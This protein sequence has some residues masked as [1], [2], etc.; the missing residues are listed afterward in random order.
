MTA[1]AALTVRHTARRRRRTEAALLVLAWFLSIGARLLTQLASSDTIPDDTLVMAAL[2][3][4]LFLASH[5]AVRRLA[6]NASPVLLPLAGLLAGIG[7]AVVAR[8]DPGRA[9]DQGTWIVIGI[10]VFVGVLA[11]LRDYRVLDRYRYTLLALGVVLL[12]LPL[13]PV[14]GQTRNGSRLWVE[15]PGLGLGFQPAEFAK[16]LLVAFFASYLGERRELIAIAPRKV[17][18][19]GIPDLKHFGPVLAVWGLTMVVMIFEKDLGSSLLIFAVFLAMLYTA[20]A[21]A[22]YVLVGLVLF[23]IGALIAYELFGHVQTRVAGWLDPFDPE[24]VGA[25]TFQ[26]A[27]SLFALAAGGLWGTGLGLGYGLGPDKPV[28]LP[29]R[30]TD[31]IFVAYAYELG[32]VGAVAMLLA[33]LTLV[34]SGMR[35]AL[36]CAEPFGKLLAAGLSITLGV[37]SFIIIGG[38]TRVIPLTGITLPFVSYGGSSILANM[39]ILAILLAISDQTVSGPRGHGLVRRKPLAVGTPLPEG[40]T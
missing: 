26:I 17:A 25:G 24:T 18:G 22:A 39:A 15:V 10:A 19:V 34:V 40:A 8:L 2:I 6:P 1:D 28:L 4:A 29:E 31:S 5:L 27:Q 23:A 21:R 9:T 36:R 20:T 33:Y 14:I 12:L 35:V 3:G 38:V 16:V 32:F 13:V 30:T 7:W 37:Q 11:L